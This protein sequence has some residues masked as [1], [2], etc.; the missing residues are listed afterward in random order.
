LVVRGVPDPLLDTAL[1]EDL[2]N[3]RL[4]ERVTPEL[5]IVLVAVAV[6][7]ADA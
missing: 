3:G 1:S 4:V 7:A 5:G 2:G 6:P